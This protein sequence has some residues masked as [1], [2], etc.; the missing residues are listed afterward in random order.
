MLIALFVLGLLIVAAHIVVFWRT[1]R[2]VPFLSSLAWPVPASWPRVSIVI[3]ARNEAAELEEALRSKLAL[4]YPSLELV[5]VNDR[6]TDGTGAILDALA[7]EDGRIVPVHLDALPEGWLGKVHAMHRGIEAS[8]GSYLLL[9]DADVHFAPG[10]LRKAIGWAES[11]GLDHVTA[12]PTVRT[13]GLLLQATLTSVLRLILAILRPWAVKDP[14][15]S[16]SAGVGAFNLFRRSAY[17]RT[18]GLAWLRME[19]GDD[20]G[21]GQMLK[22]SGARS[23]V[24]NARGEL[25]LK[26][27]SSLGELTRHMEKSPGVGGL[28]PA[29]YM[30]FAAAI[31][32]L[33]LAP[34]VLALSPAAPSWMRAAAA[35]LALGS[36]GQAMAMSRWLGQPVLP[37]LLTPVGATFFCGVALRASALAA[38]RGGIV[39][40]D[41]FYPRDAL[42]AGA[43]FRIMPRPRRVSQGS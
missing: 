23:A 6:S 29:V 17:A 26:F 19:V 14:A 5:V 4:D 9:S 25:S 20:V 42:R 28:A 39:W 18:P 8:S 2:H 13:T 35:V 16:A 22:L 32:I 10:S 31:W 7:A 24:V 38:L 33:E 1:V 12:L 37:G 36:V 34:F 21:L 40:R 15:S 27:Y 30:A 3:P 11:E 43:R 41:T